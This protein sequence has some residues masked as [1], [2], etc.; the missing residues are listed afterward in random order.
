M[1]FLSTGPKAGQFSAR[2][3]GQKATVYI[4]KQLV[5]EETLRVPGKIATNRE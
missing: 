2:R 1:Y 5:T 3:L 4:V